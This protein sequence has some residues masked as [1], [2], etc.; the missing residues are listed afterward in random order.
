M[1][2]DELKQKKN[3]SIKDFKLIAL[4][5]D[6]TLM[7]NDY[8]LTE[9][10]RKAL[11]KAMDLGL[12]VT[13][14]TGRY[15]P[16]TR[17]IARSIPINAPIVTNDGA[18][19]KDVFTNETILEK[20][21]PLETAY[22][23]LELAASFPSFKIQI[24][25]NETKIYVG[26][27]NKIMQFHRLLNFCRRHPIKNSIN[28]LRDF[29]FIPSQNVINIDGAKRA[30]KQ[31][32]AKIVIYGDDGELKEFKN[33]LIKRYKN[34]IFLTSAIPRCVD[35]LNGEISKAKG[36]EVL[37]KLLGIKREEIIAVGDNFNDMEML[38]FAGLGVAMG[39]APDMVKQ[40]ADLVTDS[41]DQDGVAKLIE[42][43]LP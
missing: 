39:N 35:V 29:I 18:L 9:R 15:Y 26:V 37:A 17:R 19:I 31:S 30:M 5:I 7:N 4:D 27:N 33:E 12:K 41:N 40:T 28:F 25:M 1:H 36:L 20:P 14:A 2:I 21:L 22:E 13:I 23:I 43:M 38:K 3:L 32:P 34:S 6:G 24:F 10:T 16:S 11:K 42:I 8:E